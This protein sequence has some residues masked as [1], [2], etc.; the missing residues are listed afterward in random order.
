[1]S[2]NENQLIDT[3]GGNQR[4]RCL[5]LAERTTIET[6][7]AQ[8]VPIRQI[9]KALNR[10]VSA[11][12]D[13]LR[14]NARDILHGNLDRY[15]ELH[16]QGAAIAAAKG[17]TRPAEWALERT[18]VVEKDTQSAVP[19]GFTVK[20]GVVLPGLGEGARLGIE[21]GVDGKSMIDAELDEESSA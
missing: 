12:Y 7:R 13:A 8:N 14:E 4:K 16:Q 10:S 5:S 21:A 2:E 9:A 18:K 15:A 6:L 1:M 20:I 19:T 11:V 3:T 17:D